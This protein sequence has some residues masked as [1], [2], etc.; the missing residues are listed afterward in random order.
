MSTAVDANVVIAWQTPGHVF[1]EEAV[2]W[3]GEAEPP[4]IM[5][6]LNL[7]EVLVG[8]PSTVWSDVIAAL[9]TMGFEFV[10][11]NA[12]EIAE[13]RVSTGLRMPDACVL[14]AAHQAGADTVLTFD[15]TLQS[16]ATAQGFATDVVGP[17]V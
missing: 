4:L 13:A 5:N 16:A 12:R 7:A 3:I 11:T 6:E 9:E 17:P 1:H 10:T 2:R 15:T 14:A 8:L